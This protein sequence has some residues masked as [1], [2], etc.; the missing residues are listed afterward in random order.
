MAKNLSA[1]RL[2]VCSWSLRPSSADDLIEKI[3]AC[4][5]SAVQLHLDPV[6]ENKPGWAGAGDRLRSA[7]VRVVSGMVAC[8]GEDYSTIARIEQTGG[9]VPD[10]SWPDTRR[11]FCACLPVA[12]AMGVKLVT[13]HAGFIPADAA[14]PVRAKVRQ[15]INAIAT[16]FASSGIHIALE[17]GQESAATLRAFLADVGQTSVGVNFDPA[18]M[19]LYGSGEPIAALRELAPLVRQVHLKDAEPSGFHGRWGREMPLGQGR[20]DWQE[21]LR[22]LGEINFSAALVIE[23]EA[24]DDRIGDVRSAAE[25][26]RSLTL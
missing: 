21:F 5:L 13:F 15:R 12:Q 26:V 25:L 14:S 10:A 11:R 24:G 9:V 6:A 16:L 18:N 1:D 20:V 4:G 7:G 22:T 2:A 17:T 19:L 23:R 8:V 3:R